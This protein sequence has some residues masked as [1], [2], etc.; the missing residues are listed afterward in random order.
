MMGASY[1]G[2]AALWAAA[3]NP[4][5]YRCAVSFAGVSDVGAMLQYDRG[6]FS[7]RRYYTKWRKTVAGDKDFDP[8]S[9]SPLQAVDRISI[10]LLIAH[11][12]HDEIV[13]ASQSKQLHDAL[14]K[15][16]KPHEYVVYPGEGHGFEQP[17]HATDFL[18]RVDAFLS[19]NNPAD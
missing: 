16:G 4:Q 2:Y 18:E 5:T 7:A 17:E 9:I 10:P 8:R 3:R 6:M 12:D 15:A 1:G 14:T 19:K 13:P 11:G